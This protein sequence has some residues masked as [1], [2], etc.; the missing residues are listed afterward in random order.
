[1]NTKSVA[2]GQGLIYCAVSETV[3]FAIAERP[4]DHLRQ[5]ALGAYA[6]QWKCIRWFEQCIVARTRRICIEVNARDRVFAFKPDLC[7]AVQLQ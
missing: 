1:M 4:N 7:S 3:D 5:Y 2:C 6:L